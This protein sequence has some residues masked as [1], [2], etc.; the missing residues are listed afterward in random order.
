MEE[1]ALV[2]AVGISFSGMNRT[3]VSPLMM[4]TASSLTAAMG[5][6][7]MGG[8]DRGPVIID[9]GIVARGDVI[10]GLK[11]TEVMDLL[12]L[13]RTDRADMLSWWELRS[14]CM[15]ALLRIE[16]FVCAM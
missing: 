16:R 13:D 4:I 14:S 6:E 15:L 7:A 12:L 1:F 8:A 10:F 9:G 5:L 3:Y 11:T 2:E